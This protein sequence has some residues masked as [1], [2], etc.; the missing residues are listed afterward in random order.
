MLSEGLLGWILNMMRE[1]PALLSY[2]TYFTIHI[3]QE[4]NWHVLRLCIGSTFHIVCSW[5]P[6]H[7]LHL[8]KKNEQ[9]DFEQY[10]CCDNQILFKFKQDI[11]R[12]INL[13]RIRIKESL[14]ILKDKDKG[15]FEDTKG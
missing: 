9:Y 2:H 3:H 4:E 11:F 7:K 5:F 1:F 6:V 8:W 13:Q 12:Q 10:F 15:K 14:R